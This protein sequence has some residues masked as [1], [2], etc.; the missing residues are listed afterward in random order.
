MIGCLRESKKNLSK[1]T[2]N[3]YP[4]HKQSLQK[5]MELDWDVFWCSEWLYWWETPEVFLK[6]IKVKVSGHF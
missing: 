3:N 4:L 6:N 2:E 5:N 1:W